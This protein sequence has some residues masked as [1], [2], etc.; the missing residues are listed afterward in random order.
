MNVKKNVI[1]YLEE[2]NNNQVTITDLV[3]K[4]EQE[5]GDDAFS[6]IH[7]KK[8]LKGHFGDSIIITE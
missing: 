7:M 5:C 6:T 4:M 8:K 1:E 2:N 3:D